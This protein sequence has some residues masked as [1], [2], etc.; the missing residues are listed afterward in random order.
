MEYI[1]WYNNKHTNHLFENTLVMHMINAVLVTE[2][3]LLSTFPDQYLYNNS[4][5]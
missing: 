3:S 2:T 4:L 5:Q 1:C